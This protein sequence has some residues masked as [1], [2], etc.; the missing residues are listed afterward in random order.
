MLGELTRFRRTGVGRDD[1]LVRDEVVAAFVLNKVMRTVAVFAALV[2]KAAM[3][4]IPDLGPP[5]LMS[6]ACWKA[7]GDR[8]R[9]GKQRGLTLGC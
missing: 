5:N 7:L 4:D 9:K 6:T 3:D 1:E 2:D 8:R